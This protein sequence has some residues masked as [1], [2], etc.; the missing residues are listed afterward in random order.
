MNRLDG[1]VAIVTGA[2]SGIG[3]AIARIF[4]GEGAKVVATDVDIERLEQVVAELNNEFGKV[5]LAVEQNVVNEEDWEK[6]VEAGVKE[7]GKINVLVNNAGIGG[8]DVPIDEY[9]LNEWNKVINVDATGNFLG[10]KHVVPEMKKANGGSII[11]ISSLAS[12]L[13]LPSAGISYSAAKGATRSLAK[14]VA[15]QLLLQIYV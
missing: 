6:V 9:P 10:I 15:N 4:V 12:M 11:N 14:V 8:L 13:A 2:A 3:L 1:K 5:A 7:F